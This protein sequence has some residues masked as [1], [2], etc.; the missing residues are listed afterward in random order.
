MRRTMFETGFISPTRRYGVTPTHM[1]SAWDTI[2]NIITKVGTPSPVPTTAAP[3]A[4]APVD[5]ILGIPSGV[6]IVGIVVVTLGAVAYILE[7]KKKTAPTTSPKKVS[8]R[9][10]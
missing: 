2:K 6:F 4:P 1:G 8:G 10:R 7:Q 5:T 3:M 9:R